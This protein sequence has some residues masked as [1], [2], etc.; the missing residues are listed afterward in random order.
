MT[1]LA[2][3]KFSDEE[4]NI[5]REIKEAVQNIDSALNIQ[6]ERYGNTDAAW[7]RKHLRDVNL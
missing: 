1:N 6:E 3:Q 5:R 7:I 2:V 4:E